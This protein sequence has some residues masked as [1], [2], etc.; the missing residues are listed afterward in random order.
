MDIDYAIAQINFDQDQANKERERNARKEAYTTADGL[1]ITIV[2]T[3]EMID[4]HECR[5]ARVSF[6]APTGFTLEKYQHSADVEY[7]RPREEGR[8]G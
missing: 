4:D 3:T 5:L 1:T 7:S 6:Q 2:T 8:E